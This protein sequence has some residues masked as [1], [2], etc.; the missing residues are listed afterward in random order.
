MNEYLLTIEPYVYIGTGN[1]TVLFFNTL[2]NR[3]L[4]Y[5]DVRIMSIAKDVIDSG[6]VAIISDN[7]RAELSDFINDIRDLF[8]GDIIKAGE[9][10]PF[11]L[12]NS[13]TYIND[14]NRLKKG[15][16]LDSRKYIKDIKIQLSS[17][18]EHQCSY[19]SYAYKQTDICT[20]FSDE[21]VN[22]TPDK[23]RTI[24]SGLKSDCRIHL[25]ITHKPG[26][27]YISDLFDI[28]D[29]IRDR[30]FFYVHCNNAE[31]VKTIISRGYKLNIIADTDN[32]NKISVVS[33]NISYSFIVNSVDEFNIFETYINS[34]NIS[35]Y[36]YVPLL[37]NNYNFFTDNICFSRDDI[38]KERTSIKKIQQNRLFNISDYG[39][40]LINPYGDISTNNNRP[41]L[42]NIFTDGVV[43]VLNSAI[44]S[45][46]ITWNMTR[47]DIDMCKDCTMKY[48]CPSP[49]G[50]EMYDNNFSMCGRIS[51]L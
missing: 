23:L 26:N 6:G 11:S 47:D 20:K 3:Y 41:G 12:D 37:N 18:C 29:T 13:K 32:L 25:I 33:D 31:P 21:N 35:D 34:N 51:S 17:Y 16:P 7:S 46:D 30:V 2:D 1:D 27:D 44:L 9:N 42:G 10:S 19:C 28:T 43:S 24:L 22:I 8:I 5:T 45:G 50:Y 48:L 14:L 40:V 39:T 49:S 36:R 15:E 4:E 38:L